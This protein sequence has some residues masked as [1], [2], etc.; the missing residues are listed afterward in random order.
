MFLRNWDKAVACALGG[1]TYYSDKDDV[2]FKT[3]EGKETS[4]STGSKNVVYLGDNADKASIPSLYKV[5]TSYV[6]GGGVMF[7]TGTTPPTKDDYCLSG[8]LLKNFSCSVGVTRNSD[9]AGTTYKAIYTI[10]NTGSNDMTIGEIGLMCN[11]Y[12]ESNTTD[13]R[14]GFIE[15]TVLDAPVTIPAG[16]IGQVTYTIRI[17]Y[18]TA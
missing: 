11:M 5:Q 17:N 3:Y 2:K 13:I 14:K 10:T 9:D 7:G 8:T 4:I 18:P 1:S 15:R 6:S 16:G 12:D